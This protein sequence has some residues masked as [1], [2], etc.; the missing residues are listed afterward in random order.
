M[1]RIAASMTDALVL[2]KAVLEKEPIWYGFDPCLIED[3]VGF[4]LPIV[5]EHPAIPILVPGSVEL[6]TASL[7]QNLHQAEQVLASEVHATNFT[8][9]KRASQELVIRFGLFGVSFGVSDNWYRVHFGATKCSF[10]Q[11]S[12]PPTNRDKTSSVNLLY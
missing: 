2:R 6:P 10:P 8:R 1:V 7:G 5:G 4:D 3:P 9:G 12:T 11:K